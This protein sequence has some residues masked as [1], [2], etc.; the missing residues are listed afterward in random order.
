MTII[1]VLFLHLRELACDL[2]F[3]NVANL[4]LRVNGI[5]F[6][7]SGAAHHWPPMIHR[8]VDLNHGVV[9]GTD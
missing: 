6:V 2:S 9:C 3:A 5:L 1:F 7:S 4:H 8:D